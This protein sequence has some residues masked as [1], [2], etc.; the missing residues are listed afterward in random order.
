MSVDLASFAVHMFVRTLVPNCGRSVLLDVIALSAT[1]VEVLAWRQAGP[2][3]QVYL[4]THDECKRA[5]EV[6]YAVLCTNPTYSELEHLAL[7]DALGQDVVKIGGRSVIQDTINK[8]DLAWFGDEP[9][10]TVLFL[11]ARGAR[12]SRVQGNSLSARAMDLYLIPLLLWVEG[13]GG[14]R[15]PAVLAR[16]IKGALVGGEE[17]GLVY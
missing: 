5:I 1:R 15:L 3:L 17:V 7:W 4:P 6:A 9:W 16:L 11:M 13:P 2:I 8:H 12:P 14:E 10:R